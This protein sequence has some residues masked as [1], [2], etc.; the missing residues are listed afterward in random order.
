MESRSP[1]PSS[2]PPTACCSKFNLPH[3]VL[4]L[5]QTFHIKSPLIAEMPAQSYNLT[6]LPAL[7]LSSCLG[8]EKDLERGRRVAVSGWLWRY[9]KRHLLTWWVPQDVATPQKCKAKVLFPEAVR[10]SA[11]MAAGRC[12]HLATPDNPRFT[13]NPHRGDNLRPS[14][15]LE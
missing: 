5:T 15:S 10:P 11:D 8:V 3:T 13:I 7:I 2:L 14:V 9:K 6:C 12:P 4:K 1:P